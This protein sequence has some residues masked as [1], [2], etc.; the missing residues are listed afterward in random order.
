MLIPKSCEERGLFFQKRPKKVKRV[1]FSAKTTWGWSGTPHSNQIRVTPTPIFYLLNL[2]VNFN[3]LKANFPILKFTSW[4]LQVSSAHSCLIF[5][6]HMIC[7]LWYNPGSMYSQITQFQCILMKSYAPKKSVPSYS[8]RCFIIFSLILNCK[9]P[10]EHTL[11][12]DQQMIF[13][14]FK[15]LCFQNPFE[16]TFYMYH[17]YYGTF[18]HSKF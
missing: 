15:L 7:R 11:Q 18:P 4:Q 6:K 5:Q 12:S 3:I 8:V 9:V 13:Q 1:P 2:K 10:W 17:I 14:N 16:Q